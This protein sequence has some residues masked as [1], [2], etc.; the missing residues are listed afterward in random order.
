[1]YQNGQ[2]L[3]RAI[4]EASLG[5]AVLV[6]PAV[7]LCGSL[8][9]RKKTGTGWLTIK[10]AT[11]D[12]NL[13]PEGVRISP[14]QKQFMPT[15]ISPGFNVPPVLTE[16]GAHHYRLI[17]LE[18]TK[19]DPTAFIQ[20][21]VVIDA[22][23]SLPEARVTDMAQFPHDI[24]IDR[25]YIHGLPSNDMKRGIRLY[26]MSCAV[27]D[28]Y[29]AEAH[30]VGQEAQAILFG[31]G[32]LK[33]YNNYLEAA[34]ENLFAQDCI[35]L[36]SAQ[37]LLS[38]TRTTALLSSVSDL[39]VGDGIAIWDGTTRLYTHVMA[40]SGN[41]V[42]YE[43]LST[44]PS[45]QSIVYWGRIATDVDIS[46]NYLFKPLSWN[47]SDPS[48]A[49]YHPNVKNLFELKAARRVWFHD[50]I[51][52]NNWSDGQDGTAILLTV[53]N[54]IGDCYFCAVEDV[55]LEG[56]IVSNAFKGILVLGTD[57]NAISGPTQNILLKNNLFL[58]M[59]CCLQEGTIESE[60]IDHNTILVG[61]YMMS[62][63]KGASRRYNH[64]TNNI[65]ISSFASGLHYN[66][67]TPPDWHNVFPGWD[68]RSN[69]FTRIN[70][71]PTFLYMRDF[72]SDNF[73]VDSPEDIGFVDWQNQDLAL[74]T[75]S[76]ARTVATDGGAIGADVASLTSRRG[77]VISGVTKQQ[78]SVIPVSP[79]H[80]VRVSPDPM[81]P[82]VVTGPPVVSTRP[83]PNL[84]SQRPADAASWDR[85][86]AADG[87]ATGADVATLTSYPGEV[88]SGATNQPTPVTPD[89]APQR[90]RVSPGP[91][92]PVA[93]AAPPVVST[94]AAPSIESSN[95]PYAGGVVASAMQ[96][97]GAVDQAKTLPQTSVSA[98][99][100]RRGNV[101][102]STYGAVP[103]RIVVCTNCDESTH[104]TEHSDKTERGFGKEGEP[105]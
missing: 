101:G 73:E 32:P 67:G 65:V 21:M 7:Y 17:G 43:S 89:S 29:I 96:Q 23:Q 47:P 51:L 34:G 87:N 102:M 93:L 31:G 8:E 22:N 85:T 15:I 6:P 92:N 98:G 94:A 68:F 38:P 81:K 90:A 27:I 71:F 20:E 4:D 2:A 1:M 46:H 41:Q 63:D 70:G 57:Y 95:P 54:Q 105:N 86:V 56:N 60:M 26:C 84:R 25:C 79:P 52:E 75:T 33:I 72:E 83:A 91:I 49:G 48:Y 88:S 39:N 50:N 30:V 61:G 36:R 9:L 10:A 28:S 78:T 76:W 58:N 18:I 82:V 104:D 5:D 103:V 11:T 37:F 53:R 40:I 99:I 59:T 45:S 44:V 55:T 69:V 74:S 62:V 35:S 42:D 80:R 97:S 3:Q 77:E 66:D 19:L 100:A 16:S 24:I 12:V 64:I 13:P 14:A